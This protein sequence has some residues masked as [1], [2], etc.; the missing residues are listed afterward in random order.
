[1]EMFPYQRE[2]PGLKSNL[3][4]AQS[5]ICVVPSATAG[6]WVS[7]YPKVTALYSCVQIPAIPG[8]VHGSHKPD[9]WIITGTFLFVSS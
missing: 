1:M 3:H 9:C 7:K 8:A 5:C 2:I 4:I 6:C